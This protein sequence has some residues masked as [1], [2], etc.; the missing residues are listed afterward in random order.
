M[1]TESRQ[2]PCTWLLLVVASV[3]C[4]GQAAAPPKAPAA[5]PAAV[6]SAAAAPESAALAAP[7]PRAPGETWD[8]VTMSGAKV[9]Y[10]HTVV[11]E[12]ERDGR[13]VLR[14]AA[15]M[16][17][18][19]NRFGDSASPQVET[20]T[21]ETADG[22]IVAFE[23]RQELSGQPTTRS[24]EFDGQAA[25]MRI[26][27][28]GRTET[29]AIALPEGT[30]G[31][32]AVDESLAE[33]PLLPGEERQLL[34]FDPSFGMVMRVALRADK[35]ESTAVLGEKLRLLRVEVTQTLP[36]GQS[37]PSL[38]WMDA[39][40]TPRKVA[41]AGMELVRTSRDDAL[42]DPAGERFDLGLQTLVHLDRPEENPH[43]A[44]VTRYR[45]RLK[46]ADPAQVFPAG[47]TQQVRSLDERTA[48]IT[49]RALRPNDELP[50]GFVD[51][52]PTDDDRGPNAMLQSDDER[53][54]RLAAEV[55]ADDGDPWT[56]A[57]ALERLVR[58]SITSRNFSTA[59]ASAAEVAETRA[60]DCTEHAV[61]LA[62]LCRAREIPARVAVGLVYVE[63]A[64]AFG[65]HMWTEV[66][67]ADRWL[68]LDATLGRG[69]IGGGHLKLAHSNL[70]DG[71][72]YASFV[73]VVQV[74]GQV[75]IEVIED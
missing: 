68:P 14:I 27:V 31:P 18:Q 29:Q 71:D 66:Y 75:E 33:K 32:L 69:G 41:I 16:R 59:L 74:L 21:Y 6:E 3:G 2:W 24:A 4:N 49:V 57:V 15:T 52:P 67:V 39:G 63:A 54:R 1:R 53:V 47:A 38:L 44:K 8:A 30:R 20:A 11:S 61:L 48:E 7:S 37:M 22:R 9:G 26:T 51:Q 25:E 10:L 73:P 55:A 45:V 72:A 40:G 42:R 5:P 17:L 34:V 23:C 62:A 50:A 28:A 35:Y 56:T 65:Y 12:V 58:R 43:T 64:S 36:D 13:P 46:E 60:G 70:R 19:V